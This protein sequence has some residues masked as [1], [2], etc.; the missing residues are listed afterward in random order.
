MR[1]AAASLAARRPIHWSILISTTIFFMIATA[2]DAVFSGAGD[3]YRSGCMAMLKREVTSPANLSTSVR[4]A[5]CSR[6]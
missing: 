4:R 3:R 5:S 6:L 1:S 2:R